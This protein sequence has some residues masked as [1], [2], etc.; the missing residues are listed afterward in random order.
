[1]FFF[2]GELNDR[3]ELSPEKG[4]LKKSSKK[5][6]TLSGEEK[7]KSIYNFRE[8]NKRIGLIND[9]VKNKRNF[10]INSKKL[11]KKSLC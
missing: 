8:Q 2:K 10:S 3:I 9:T 4:I 11:S 1:M 6:F 7:E 5:K